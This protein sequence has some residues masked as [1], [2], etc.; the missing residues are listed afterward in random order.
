MPWQVSA[1]LY[2]LF[3]STRAIQNRRIGLYKTD[4]TAYALAASFVCVFTG[5]LLYA[6]FS[7]SSVDHEA[8]RNAWPFLVVGGSLFGCINVLII[9]TYRFLP[10]SLAIFMGILNTISVIL[11]AYIFTEETLSV[12][13]WIGATILLTAIILVAMINK[14]NR[15]TKYQKSI[16]IGIILTVLT[17][18]LFGP[19]LLNEK[20][21]INRLGLETYVVYGWGLQAISAF[22][23]AY[24]IH[25]NT[26]MKGRITTKMHVDV[27]VYGL[28]LILAGLMFVLSLQN[29]GSASLTA[30]ISV[31]NVVL[32][33]VLAYIFLKERSYLLAK[34]VGII[35]TGA[36]LYLLFS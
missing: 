13:Q 35:L 21:L 30:I 36:G 20:Y 8:A 19:A 9:K 10:A 28:L 17:A 12:R 1:L 16:V 2:I 14:R 15:A 25:K 11:F 5:G 34:S 32:T 29:S 3:S 7:W 31:A 23:L 27:W 18:F 4:L 26:K 6:L 24:F 33:A 22:I